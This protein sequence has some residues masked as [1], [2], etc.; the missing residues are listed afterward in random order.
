M[1]STWHSLV[2]TMT[3]IYLVRALDYEQLVNVR[4]CLQ[5]I[6][7][8]FDKKLLLIIYRIQTGLNRRALLKEPTLTLSLIIIPYLVESLRWTVHLSNQKYR[9]PTGDYL[10]F[11]MVQ[12]KADHIVII[13]DDDT[14]M[15][16]ILKLAIGN[17]L[18]NSRR[19]VLIIADATRMQ[20]PTVTLHTVLHVL[21]RL[22]KAVNATLMWID[23]AEIRFLTIFP[24]HDCDHFEVQLISTWNEQNLNL[25]ALYPSKIP[26][27]LNLCKIYVG[28]AGNPPYVARDVK[29]PGYFD[30]GLEVVML[31][32]IAQHL[33]FSM[34]YKTT[35]PGENAWVLVSAAGKLSGLFGLLHRQ[36]ADI[37]AFGC[38]LT[39]DRYFA[40]EA[41]H[42]HTEDW[43]MWIVPTPGPASNWDSIYVAYSFQIWI[44]IGV[45]LL[46]V[47]WTFN[48][49]ANHQQE[50]QDRTTFM[51]CLMNMWSLTLNIPIPKP[52]NSFLLRSFM[53]TFSLYAFN[54]ASAYQSYLT[55]LLT[56]KR[57]GKPI[58]T[59]EEAI[60][61]GL[62]A[63]LFTSGKNSYNQSD[64]QF[65]NKVLSPNHHEYAM[66]SSYMM[67]YVAV[68]KTGM[69]L[70]NKNS[71]NYLVV[72]KFFQKKGRPI[73]RMLTPKFSNFDITMFVSPG[74]PLKNVLNRKIKQLMEGGFTQLWLHETAVPNAALFEATVDDTKPLT[75]HHLQMV[76]VILTV[77]LLLGTF[78]LLCELF[79][80]FWGVKVIRI[81]RR[82]KRLVDLT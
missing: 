75:M 54:L 72:E 78:V 51:R 53:M 69:M 7:P 33:N 46:L 23:A 64:H 24:Y 17:A 19:K 16:E 40:V 44:T 79:Q 10:L 26:G 81:L 38:R 2:C 66:N 15:T 47:S 9:S 45:F 42:S 56:A 37:A 35:P 32:A 73:I 5:D 41:L 67:R 57:Q 11:Q 70:Y 28:M 76:F 82:V 71:A 25:K 21:W 43:F 6:S 31:R 39:A 59:P 62:I 48:F 3:F 18:W 4:K 55:T 52:P 63:Y 68:E 50:A 36:E 29:T 65:W 80:F 8:M 34:Q 60:D 12:S 20:S 77:S 30:D 1:V 14:D 74:H 13:F 61:A 49:I 22:S 27:N 58:E